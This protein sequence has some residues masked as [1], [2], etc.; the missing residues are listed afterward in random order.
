VSTAPTAVPPP[1]G[2][3]GLS[4]AEAARR[5][6]AAGPAPEPQASRSLASILRAN[7]LTVFNLILV[8]FGVVTLAFGDWRD[9][10]FLAILVLN[11]GIGIAQELRAKRA[12]DRL[13][14]LVAPVARVVRD[15]VPRKVPVEHVVPGDLLLLDAGEAVAADGVLIRAEG[16]ALDESVLT[17]ESSPRPRE[18]GDRVR[19]GA[20]CAEGSG[21]FVADAVGAASY[22]QRVTGEARSFRHPRSPLEREL[23]RLLLVLVGCMVPLGLLLG[24]ALWERSTSGA[25]AVSTATAAVVTLVPEGLILLT[26]L[27]F[28]VSALRVARHGALAQQLSAVEALAA[29][30]VVCLD[31][32]GTLTEDAVRVVGHRPAEGVGEEELGVLAG[33]YAAAWPAQDET[34]A[35]LGT[36]WPA[37]PETADE[38]VPF[39]S[40]RRWAGVRLAGTTVVLGAPERF[41]LG[42]LTDAAR[43]E[44]EAGRR[45]LCLARGPAPL[46]DPGPD[47]PPPPG[48]DVVGIVTMAERLRPDAAEAV[49][50]LHGEG[51]RVVVIS[52]D[53]PATAGAVAAD[54][55]VPS[56]APAIDAA[57]LPPGGEA[58]RAA[59]LGAGVVGRADPDDKR[60]IVEAL[61]AGGSTVGMVGDGVNDVPALRAARLAIAPGEGAE[62]ARAV[63][64]LVLVR[65]GFAAVPPMI[66]EGR[67]VLRNLQR[68]SK[69]FVTKSALAAFLILT[70]GLTPTSYPFLPRHLTLVSA[71]TIGIPAFFI[72]LAA[73]RGPW[74]AEGFLAD[75]A[76]FALPAGVAAGLGV[77]S[78]FLFALNVADLDLTEARTVAVTVLVLVGLWFVLILEATGRRRGWWVVGLCLAMLALYALCL[79]FPGPREFFEL[80]VPG[81]LAVASALAG[82]GMAAAGL[83]LTDPRFRPGLVTGDLEE[84]PPSRL[85]TALGRAWD[86]LRRRGAPEGP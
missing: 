11:A 62:M 38:R 5:R 3:G 73:S 19:A 25:D 58:L 17:G 13:A 79:A 51:V 71:L 34:V 15:H 2:A 52:G 60:R 82:A 72:A 80:A 65:G 50:F 43:A 44:Q 56:G 54:A 29:V 7:L 18:P 85:G 70:V 23:N 16:L 83:W 46:G 10:L 77:V 55:G 61:T 27:T 31:K 74:R 81:A 20:F 36:R 45:V 78:S 48:L 4:E 21:A 32:T 69:L 37:V 84:E 14:A 1:G 35:A 49:G 86:R 64:D 24:A 33:R 22:A 30:D 53:A 66:A 8:A 67:R 75:V 12:L 57:D 68:V 47:G 42:P 76:R 59:V 41:E 6:A 26:S 28:A 40:R 9:A 63:A 39:S